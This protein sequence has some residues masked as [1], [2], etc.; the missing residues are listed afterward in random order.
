MPHAA[1]AFT[2]IEMVT[3]MAIFVIL[4]TAGVSLLSGTGSQSRKAATAMLSGLIVQARNI[5]IT[6]RS[7][8]FLVIAEPGDIP[9]A[10]DRCRIGLF[11]KKATATADSVAGEDRYDQIS[12][13]QMLNPG[14]VL[15]GGKITGGQV[16]EVR[17]SMDEPKMEIIYGHKNLKITVHAIS[18]NSR[19]GLVTPKG[20][21]PILFRIA[22]GGYRNGKAASN[23]R[24]GSH[25][26]SENILK[27]GRVTARPYQTN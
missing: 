5:A 8:V 3:V 2:L 20:S 26:I 14:I 18:I 12:R 4:M 1:N 23:T 24:T 27:I 6:S 9:G 22:E 7:E 13:W 11:R 16:D 17:N 10:D 21:D 25:A 15:L 19:G